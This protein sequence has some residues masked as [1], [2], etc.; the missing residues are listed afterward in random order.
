MGRSCIQDV[1]PVFSVVSESGKQ[2]LYH[3]RK[4]DFQAFEPSILDEIIVTQIH[5]QV[6]GDTYFPE[7]VN[8]LS[9]F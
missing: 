4:A 1:E 7:G 8:G 6:G 9:L 2:S 3:W 5:A